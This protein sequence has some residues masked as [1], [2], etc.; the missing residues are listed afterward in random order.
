M[1]QNWKSFNILQLNNIQPQATIKTSYSQDA[2]YI[3]ELFSVSH[4]VPKCPGTTWAL[5][6]KLVI[7][8]SK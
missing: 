4:L 8:A 5:I 6:Q 1:P 3:L 7:S 2:N